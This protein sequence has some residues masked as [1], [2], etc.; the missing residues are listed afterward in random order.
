MNV[1]KTAIAS[2]NS[3]VARLMIVGPMPNS[4]FKLPI[5]QPVPVAVLCCLATA[6]NARTSMC[7]TKNAIFHC[8]GATT[9][10][11]TLQSS[12]ISMRRQYTIV[13][14]SFAI[15]KSPRKVAQVEIRVLIPIRGRII[16]LSSQSWYFRVRILRV[17]FQFLTFALNSASRST[18]ARRR[19]YR[20]LLTQVRNHFD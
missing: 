16:F 11:T 9:L 2:S 20:L 18:N 10:R 17:A 6:T 14:L 1:N 13:S 19:S 5:L 4:S 8:K 15:S 3:V 7:A 12:Y